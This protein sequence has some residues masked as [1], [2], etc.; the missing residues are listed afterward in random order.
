D[1]EPDGKQPA[2]TAV[3]FRQRHEFD[4]VGFDRKSIRS[5][6]ITHEPHPS[7]R[8]SPTAPAALTISPERISAATALISGAKNRSSDELGTSDRI[9]ALTRSI[10]SLDLAVVMK[11]SPWAAASSSIASTSRRFS[12]M[13]CNRAAA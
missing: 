11:S 9:R 8:G 5:R 6:G 12:N 7:T 13:A 4:A 1:A 2:R 3:A 10:A